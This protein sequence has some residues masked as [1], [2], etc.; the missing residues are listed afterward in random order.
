MPPGALGHPWA[1]LCWVLAGGGRRGC[2]GATGSAPSA[3]GQRPAPAP[4]ALLLTAPVSRPACLAAHAALL[5][6]PTAPRFQPPPAERGKDAL[7][8]R[9]PFPRPA[10]DRKSVKELIVE[11]TRASTDAFPAEAKEEAAAA[12][13]S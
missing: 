11:M 1:L 8:A 3:A 5:P 7:K 9:L 6:S 12:A 2:A 4:P 13:K 10:T